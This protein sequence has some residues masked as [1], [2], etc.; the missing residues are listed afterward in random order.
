M[1]LSTLLCIVDFYF[2]W[3]REYLARVQY[4][5]S[6]L[7]RSYAAWVQTLFEEK[8]GEEKTQDKHDEV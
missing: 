1:C 2:C 6:S 5:A 7:L 8:P 3:Q 4:I